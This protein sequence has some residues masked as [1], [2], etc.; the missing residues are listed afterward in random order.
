MASAISG[1]ARGLSRWAGV[2]GMVRGLVVGCAVGR[3][4]RRVDV[5]DC[6]SDVVAGVSRIGVDDGCCLGDL[7]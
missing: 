1:M 5:G 7:G 3:N 2:I 4:L 6:L